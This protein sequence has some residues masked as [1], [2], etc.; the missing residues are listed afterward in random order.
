MTSIVG[1]RPSNITRAVVW[2]PISR[3]RSTRKPDS[4][5]TSRTLPSSDGCRLKPGSGIHDFAPRV[6]VASA[7]HGDDRHH[8]PAIDRIP[9]L[10]QARVVQA[11]HAVHQDEPDDGVDALALDVV[12]RVAR[13]VVRGRALDGDHRAGDQAER[14]QQQQRVQAQTPSRGTSGGGGSDAG[15]IWTWRSIALVR[16]GLELAVLHIE[17]LREDQA[18][19]GCRSFRAEPAALDR[20]DDHDRRSPSLTKQAYQDWSGFGGRSTVPVLP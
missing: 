18:R 3:M 10:A 7:E 6:A 2:R 4:A 16:A 11:R 12:E 5:T 13:D 19:R 9:Q 14:R 8:Q 20:H 15:W 17:P 1:N